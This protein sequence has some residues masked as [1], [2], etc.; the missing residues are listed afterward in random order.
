MKEGLMKA[1]A[2]WTGVLHPCMTIN[3][4]LNQTPEDQLANLIEKHLE[5]MPPEEAIRRLKAV[6]SVTVTGK[7][8]T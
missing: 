6:L 1:E 5:S 3:V 4:D 7:G 2:T 8:N